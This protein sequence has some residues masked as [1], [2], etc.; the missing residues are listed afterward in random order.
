MDVAGKMAGSLVMFAGLVDDSDTDF[1][2]A[3]GDTVIR[4]R[5]KVKEIERA[6][7]ILAE[8]DGMGLRNK[9]ITAVSWCGNLSPFWGFL[10][11]LA[12]MNTPNADAAIPLTS[13]EI[14]TIL[15]N[16]ERKSFRYCIPIID[17]CKALLAKQK[18][19]R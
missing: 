13:D 9:L 11:R 14:E 4:P 15:R 18:E 17:I 8:W 6:N 3:N 2:D 19:I 12:I 16:E 7:A 5:V 1:I 10:E